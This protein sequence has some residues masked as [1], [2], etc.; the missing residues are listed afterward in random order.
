MKNE[1]M[2][3]SDGQ[4]R[5]TKAKPRKQVVEGKDRW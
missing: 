3:P 1:L 5:K 4:G 2:R